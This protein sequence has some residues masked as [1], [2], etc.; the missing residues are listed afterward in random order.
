MLTFQHEKKATLHFIEELQNKN[1]ISVNSF[2]LL[3]N[4]EKK[5]KNLI[6]ASH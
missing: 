5:T 1:A 4:Y 6:I 3:K 2:P